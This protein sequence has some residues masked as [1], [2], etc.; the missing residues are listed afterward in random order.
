MPS[1]KE[2]GSSDRNQL[3][4]DPD[5]IFETELFGVITNYQDFTT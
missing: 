3:R 4:G 5:S 2:N 1:A